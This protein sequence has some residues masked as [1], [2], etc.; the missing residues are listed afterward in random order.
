MGATFRVMLADTFS[1]AL[2]SARRL[3]VWGT[4]RCIFSDDIDSSSHGEMGNMRFGDW[5]LRLF[6]FVSF[7]DG[8]DFVEGSLH[9][10]AKLVFSLE[11]LGIPSVGGA[12]KEDLLS[13]TANSLNS[14]PGN[15]EVF[16]SLEK[17]SAPSSNLFV[18]DLRAHVLV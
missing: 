14:V 13:L 15:L 18:E 12:L 5:S 16:S 10:H 17:V 8:K 6:E 4:A 1:N 7:W 11:V 9:V 2:V 3:G